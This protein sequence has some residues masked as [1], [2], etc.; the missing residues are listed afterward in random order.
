MPR[1]NC[2]AGEVREPRAA[3]L[4]CLAGFLAPRVRVGVIFGRVDKTLVTVAAQ[5][6][7]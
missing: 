7:K 1:A 4:F 2:K 5:S 3:Y 6:C